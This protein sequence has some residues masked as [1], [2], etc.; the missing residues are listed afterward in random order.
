MIQAMKIINLLLVSGLFSID[1]YQIKTKKYRV[2]SILLLQLYWKSFSP[3]INYF[4]TDFVLRCW[5]LI[6]LCLYDSAAPH[7]MMLSTGGQLYAPQ[8]D[9]ASTAPSQPDH[10]PIEP[11]HTQP[12]LSHL[13]PPPPAKV[14][15]C[16]PNWTLVLFRHWQISCS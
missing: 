6:M 3:I 2:S 13:P 15:S 7:S 9:Y 10:R 12:W 8:P 1:L 11:A 14:H 16:L 5:M 4:E